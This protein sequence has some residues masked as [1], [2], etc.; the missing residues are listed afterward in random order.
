MPPVCPSCIEHPSLAEY[1]RENAS[2]MECY[3]CGKKWKRPRAMPLYEL[4]AHMRERIEVEYE[5][6]AN[7]VGYESA[8]G[9][10]QLSTMDGYELL[11]EVGVGWLDNQELNDD[12]AAHFNDTP[13][14]HRNPYSLT[15]ERAR[16]I[17]WE[18]FV[19]LVKHRVRYL[20]WSPEHEE[21]EEVIPPAAML[22]ELGDLFKTY[23]LLHMLPKGTELVR[24]RLHA[25][26]DLPANVLS[27]FGPPPIDSARFANRM[28]PAGVSMFYAALNE[29]TALAETYVRHDG[30]PAQ[31]TIATFRL[32]ED[33]TVLDLTNL[34]SV[35]SIFDSDSANL[36]RAAIGFLHDFTD[37]LTKPIMKD[38]REHIEYVP[39]QIVTEYVR[40]RL[41]QKVGRPVHGILYRSARLD[42]GIG[43]VLFYAHEDITDAGY[44][45]NV[46]PPFEL[47]TDRT[48]TVDVDTAPVA[49]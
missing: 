35:P 20:Q 3:Y 21:D 40:Y 31:A 17:S 30:K 39:S 38:G 14:V 7:S 2:E 36:Y 15:E 18:E 47:L 49:Q 48:R 13:W 34:P 10:Y 43:C 27:A 12:L 42:G 4:L 19:N 29:A 46:P 45:P 24:V 28:S 11:D 16:R 25:P 32:T 44:G 41:E 23:D 33:L 5:D 8:E 26:G 22:D 37:D 9:G 6:A 1:I